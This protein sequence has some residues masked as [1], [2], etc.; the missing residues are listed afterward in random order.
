[1]IVDGDPIIR[2]NLREML[3][4]EGYQV[5]MECKNGEEAVEQSLKLKPDLIIMDVKLPFLNGMKA[6]KII[7]NK[8]DTAIVLLTASSHRK[9]IENAKE[10]GISAYLVKPVTEANLIPAIEIALYQQ[11]QFQS[12]SRELQSLK[13]KL[14]ERHLIEKA[15]GK[16]MEALLLSEEAAY[17]RIREYSMKNRIALAVVAGFILNKPKEFLETTLV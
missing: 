8:I 2:M 16:V 10:A 1:M 12:L 7:R 11:R 13:E 9:L 5:V 4:A 14:E 17:R 15:K 6:S 3:L